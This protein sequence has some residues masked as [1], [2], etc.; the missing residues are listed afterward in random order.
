MKTGARSTAFLGDLGAFLAGALLPPAFAPFHLFPL[1][2]ISPAILFRLWTG[3][4][5]RRAFG[6]GWLYGLGLFGVGV[7]W[8]QVSIHQ[9]GL[10]VLAF[11]VS[12]TVLFVAILALYPA[13]AG[14]SANRFFPGDER[15]CYLLALPSL[16]TAIE[17][18]RGWFLTGFPWLNLGYSQT[19][20]PL[21]G[22]APVLGVYGV[23]LAAAWSAGVLAYVSARRQRLRMLE[24]GRAHV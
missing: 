21:G 16:W 8:V 14:Y 12:A 23:S 7:S 17:W 4:S 20:S 1:A 5:A 10:P 6:R 13:G 24:I 3:V 22:L 11:S 18:L 15:L 19:D 9:F 2:V